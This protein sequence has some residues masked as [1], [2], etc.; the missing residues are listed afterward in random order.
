MDLRSNFVVS[1]A[2]IFK[3]KVGSANYGNPTPPPVW[4][5]DFCPIPSLRIT[6]FRG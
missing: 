6:K 5:G 2:Y 1:K 4:N 3:R